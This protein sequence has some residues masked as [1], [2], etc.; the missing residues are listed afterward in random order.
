MPTEPLWEETQEVAPVW[1]ETLPSSPVQKLNRTKRTP[2][3]IRAEIE[4]R[5]DP[6]RL[7]VLDR[8]LSSD[9]MQSM[10]PRAA[11]V[12]GEPARLVNA[13]VGQNVF[14]AD[15]NRPTTDF[16]GQA[17]SGSLPMP[18]KIGVNPDASVV[19]PKPY[20]PI[21]LRESLNAAPQTGLAGVGRGVGEAALDLGNAALD[22]RTIP[23]LLGRIPNALFGV[24]TLMEAPEHVRELNEKLND[25]AV[26][27]SEKVRADLNFALT[28][29]AG[30]AGLSRMLLHSPVGPKVV[31][32][33]QMDTPIMMQGEP[34]F[35]FFQ[36]DAPRRVFPMEDRPPDWNQYLVNPPKVLTS[37]EGAP[38]SVVH[39]VP[40]SAK[41]P[42]PLGG[43]VSF[44]GQG[45]PS[46]GQA[47]EMVPENAIRTPDQLS[48]RK[49]YSG[50]PLVD[51]YGNYL[52]LTSRL[53]RLILS[54]QIQSPEYNKIA[55]EIEVIKNRHD[56]M[57]PKPSGPFDEM[58][59]A[60]E[61]TDPDQMKLFA[62]VAPD[63]FSLTALRLLGNP[64]RLRYAPDKKGDFDAGQLLNRLVNEVP[65][66]EKELL[67]GLRE[68]MKPG[69]K[70][71]LEEAKN[72]VQSVS[73]KVEVK[74]LR[75]GE[76]GSTD[77]QASDLE[78]QLAETEH[79]LDTRRSG[80]RD[81]AM[82]DFGEPVEQLDQPTKDL[83]DRR[84]KLRRDLDAVDLSRRDVGFDPDVYR[85]IAPKD[86][87]Q[88]VVMVRVPKEEL[89]DSESG[90]LIGHR[91]SHFGSEDI[92]TL[93]WA[94]I[95][96][97]T[98]NGKKVAHVIE[99]QSDWGQSTLKDR[100]ELER[101]VA[102]RPQGTYASQALKEQNFHPLLR[103]YNR[104]VLKAAIEQ[105]KKDGADAV[106]LSDAQ[107]AMMSEGHDIGADYKTGDA[108]LSKEALAE[109][110]LPYETTGKVRI[111][112]DNLQNEVA[113][114]T[115]NNRV[116][117]IQDTK[118]N[119]HKNKLSELLG[120]S[121]IFDQ[122]FHDNIG[123]APQQEP[124]MRLNYDKILP[125]ILEEL[126]GSQGERV[127]FGEHQRAF[128]LYHGP[129]GE[130][131]SSGT[132]QPRSNLIFESS[133]GVKKTDASALMFNLKKQSEL[134]GDKPYTYF[135]KDKPQQLF[136]GAP[137]DFDWLRKVL[138]G[139]TPTASG[140]LEMAPQDTLRQIAT[141]AKGAGR[142][143]GLSRIMDPR[144]Y[145]ET[146]VEKGLL[147]HQLSAFT[148]TQMTALWAE[149][150][151]SLPRYFK[152]D[153][154]G[155]VTLS[156][157]TKDYMSDVI[158]REMTNPGSQP[159]SNQQRKFVRWWEKQWDTISTM[160]DK[161]G[162]KYFKDDDGNTVE[163][164]KSYFPRPAIGKGVIKNV[165]EAGKK[166]LG[167]KQFF[168]KPRKYVTERMGVEE[169]EIKYEGDE[170]GRIARLLNASYRAIA[171]QRLVKEL[172]PLELSKKS[173]MEGESVYHPAFRG[174]VFDAETANKLRKYYSDTVPDWLKGLK[175]VS[176]EVKTIQ[177]TA[178]ASTPLNQG[179]T[180]L[181]TS[182]KRWATATV[183]HFESFLNDKTLSNYLS[184]KENM[185]VAQTI[186]R[187]GGSLAHLY[188]FLEGSQKGH[189]IGRLPPVKASARMM[190]TFLSIAKIEFYKAYE[191]MLKKNKGKPGWTEADLVETVENLAMSGRMEAKGVGPSRAAAERT[192]LFN[193]PSYVRAALDN[194][195]AAT[196]E[197]GISGAA[198]R[199]SLI[200]LVTGVSL[201]YFALNYKKYQDGEMTKEEL[202]NRFDPSKSEFMRYPL[203]LPNGKRLETSLGSFYISAVRAIGQTAATADEDKELKPGLGN[204]LL[205]F[206]R[207]R[208]PPMVT[209][210]LQI[211]EGTDWKGEP[212]SA[213]ESLARAM[214][215]VGWGEP[216]AHKESWQ[217]GKPT[218]S[219]WA[220]AA[221][222]TF[223]INAFP[224]SFGAQR[225]RKLD[226]V[227][228]EMY[229]QEYKELTLNQRR[230][231]E[232]KVASG[233]EQDKKSYT[234]K[235]VA[236][237]I[238]AA[239][240]RGN[241]VEK[242][243]SDEVK[244]EMKANNLTLPG[245]ALTKSI[246]K[247][248]VRL[249]DESEVERFKEIQVKVTEEKLQQMF[250]SESWKQASPARRQ[251]KFKEKMEQIHQKAWTEFR[252]SIAPTKQ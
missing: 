250:Q 108:T 242:H 163:V 51:D 95:Q 191:P 100:K 53:K 33:I 145:R 101:M 215:P 232:K 239:T 226:Q 36:A 114:Y 183:N 229:G 137:I 162:V 142:I 234:P 11:D 153:K 217:D 73:P 39:E 141:T 233:M 48:G 115:R 107:T 40:L 218:P 55:G 143:P 212:V 50:A 69:Q 222:G 44:E 128:E 249:K 237:T 125:K 235:Q 7:S 43:Q 5:S 211:R 72:L 221:L 42:E 35:P 106:A 157:G 225:G 96:Y 105:A 37:Q 16:L 195:G 196:T 38:P 4:S 168:Q 91:G 65:P 170:Y 188:D 124:G 22:T 123:H 20:K 103:D 246:D 25:P 184:D 167:A 248:N 109:L 93:G 140:I 177:F 2:D 220:E 78:R 75:S 81:D 127:S 197:G 205:R 85:S 31:P 15:P 148:G 175:W 14:D 198:T 182:P 110:E 150:H 99:V 147:T 244:R 102:T 251:E 122:N 149:T 6:A 82:D 154:D 203:D 1:E 131:L 60:T 90:N 136:S 52:D 139:K 12:F 180:L 56:G 113:R 19:W 193:A 28:G 45:I 59:R 223:N 201:A 209:L 89:T 117:E 23:Y 29:V 21:T 86:A 132:K 8:V 80:W 186:V 231:V 13:A 199:R 194:I 32:D 181:A 112:T 68:R 160:L 169:G 34:S 146:P 76:S 214:L 64:E 130:E 172:E 164:G 66:A 156:D 62:G 252:R 77:K 240:L 92:N 47:A 165:V 119:W 41:K 129:V 236:S 144:A 27:L 189:V 174:K 10:V 230:K 98:V 185:R 70:V 134:K 94:R 116:L 187:H 3:E 46:A 61:G 121:K 126:T 24:K 161:E 9:Y 84:A 133:P 247:V 176:D 18:D 202:V 74:V 155:T 79:L 208:Q 216:L 83:L 171:D 30:A 219:A 173:F 207:Y 118:G 57:P 159:I 192:F 241:V 152:A 213:T 238:E 63:E 245:Y 49:L 135:G 151:K 190:S 200:K 138:K 179:L 58:R 87:D 243:L 54:N 104:L 120:R 71:T 227:G 17:T 111:P 26:P 166:V 206:G 88:T 204:P 67:E 178:D 210:G 228:K 97:E 158:E 224:E